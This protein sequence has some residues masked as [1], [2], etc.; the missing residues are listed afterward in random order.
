MTA[1]TIAILILVTGCQTTDTSWVFEHE[2]ERLPA[3]AY[4]LFMNQ[5]LGDASTMLQTEWFEWE[6]SYEGEDWPLH[7]FDMSEREIL[8]SN[9]EGM[10]LY[11]WVV[12]EARQISVRHI[13][14]SSMLSQYGISPDPTE[15]EDAETAA[16]REYRQGGRAFRDIGVAESSL[17]LIH[18]S[19]VMFNTLFDGLYGPGGAYEVPQQEIMSYFEDNFIKGQRLSLWKTQVF[20]EN[21]ET[22]EELAEARRLADEENEGLMQLAIEF[23]ERMEAG[24]AIEDLH[25]DL[26]RHLSPD[27][28]SVVRRATGEFDFIIRRDNIHVLTETEM[29]SLVNTPAGESVL[30]EGQEAIAMIRR[31]DMPET[32]QDLEEH[33][34]AILLW[35]RHADAFMQI[36][37]QRG[38]EPTVVEAIIFWL[39]YDDVF[40][41][42]LDQRGEELAIIVNDAAIRRYSPSRLMG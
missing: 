22:E 38:E 6:P 21:Y 9:V 4:I 34:E 23:M 42:M 35:L 16:R 29:E 19:T 25:Y 12:R 27:P 39:R 36:V 41:P 37:N 15:I 33:S 18:E 31:L 7:P 5:A 14:V 24:E 40:L 8:N 1:L 11:D 30:V 20:E 26:S 32:P 17:A 2:G 13:A 10:R 3:G 28:D